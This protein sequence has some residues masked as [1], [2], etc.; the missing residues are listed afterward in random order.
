MRALPH[1]IPVVV[2]T[3]AALAGCDQAVDLELVR[4]PEAVGVDVDLS[5]VRSAEVLALPN[6]LT[7][8]LTAACVDIPAGAMRTLDDHDLAGA[9]DM[10]A[11]ASGPRAAVL[12]FFD[13]PGCAGSP[14][15]I[16]GAVLGDGDH[17]AVPMA[18]VAGCDQRAT[19]AH[20]YQRLRH[21]GASRPSA[22]SSTPISV[23][24]T[25]GRVAWRSASGAEIVRASRS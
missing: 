3:V 2:A 14:I 8:N 7:A 19:A 4:A 15:V 21:G 5:C 24:S 16:G 17:V 10:R 12:H 23:A 20:T 1:A 25:D 13:E 6:D 18:P 9:L 11:P 22:P